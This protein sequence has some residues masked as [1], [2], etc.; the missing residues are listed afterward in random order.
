MKKQIAVVG[1]DLELIEEL[2]EDSYEIVGYYSLQK[3]N[4]EFDYLGSHK[5]INELKKGIFLILAIDDPNLRK[6]IFYSGA[7]KIETFVSKNAFVSKSAKIATGTVVY[8]NAFVGPGSSLGLCSKI[9]IGAQI[10]HETVIGEFCVIGPGARLLGRSQVKSESFLG[11]NSTVGPNLTIGMKA[12]IG[13]GAVVTRNI[14][15]DKK[16][17]GVPAKPVN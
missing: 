13:M 2:L 1:S 3:K 9:S 4:Y 7:Q 17:W 5:K 8:R 14:L 6:E 12:T 11:A 10:H 15:N 16:A